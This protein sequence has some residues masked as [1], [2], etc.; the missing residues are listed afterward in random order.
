MT[1]II[2]LAGERKPILRGRADR[3]RIRIHGGAE[4]DRSAIERDLDEFRRSL[5][6]LNLAAAAAASD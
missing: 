3:K 2:G 5:R 1:V 6:E 4:P